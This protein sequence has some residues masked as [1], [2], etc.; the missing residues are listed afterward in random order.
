M[1]ASLVGHH[2]A[3]FNKAAGTTGPVVQLNAVVPAD[4]LIVAWFTFDNFSSTTLPTVTSIGRQ[5][6]ETN[7]WVRVASVPS[8]TATAGSGAVSEIWVIETTVQWS[9]ASYAV[10]L[11]S[12]VTAKVDDVAVFAGVEPTVRGVAGSA[13]SASTTGATATTT[14][15]APVAGDLALGIAYNANSTTVPGTDTDT[16]DG[17]WVDVGTSATSGGSAA[18][19]ITQRAQYK[20]LTGTTAQS[21][22]VSS[23]AVNP[24]GAGCVVLQATPLPSAPA[25]PTVAISANS[26]AI[27]V[28]K[29]ALPAGATYFDLYREPG[30]VLVAANTPPSAVLTNGLLDPTVSYSYY[31]VAG[32]A[33]GTATGSTSSAVVPDPGPPAFTLVPGNTTVDVNINRRDY[34]A[35]YKVYRRLTPPGI[36][37]PWVGAIVLGNVAGATA[38]SGTV[39]ISGATT[40]EVVFVSGLIEDTLTAPVTLPGGWTLVT[41]GEGSQ[42]ASGGSGS[43]S[44]VAWRV[45]QAGDTTFTFSWGVAS[46]Y[47][48]IPFS[49]P[50]V[51]TTT[52][53]DVCAY[54]A[55]TASGTAVSASITPAAANRWAVG[56]FGKR[57]TT[58]AM[59]FTPD[60]ALTER[61][62]VS[63]TASRYMALELADSNGP[64]TQAAHSYT[65][66][67]TGSTAS[68]GGVLLMALIPAGAFTLVHTSATQV[69][70]G[71]YNWQDTGLVNNVDY[72]YAIATEA[73]TPT[74]R[75]SDTGTVK[76][77]APS[78]VIIYTP[79]AVISAGA[80]TGV[81]ATIPV[82]LSNMDDS[83]FAQTAGNTDRLTLDFST[84]T[85]ALISAATTVTLKY[86]TSSVF[87]PDGAIAQTRTSGGLV[88][89]D[90]GAAVGSSGGQETRTW[91]LSATEQAAWVSAINANGGTVYG[92]LLSV[93]VNSDFA[94]MDY[95]WIELDNTASSAINGTAAFTAAGTFAA[96]GLSTNPAAAA[97]TATATFNATPVRTA[98]ATAPLAAVATFTATGTIVVTQAGAVAMTAVG[99]LTP[100]V[101][102]TVIATAALSATATLSVAA[103]RSA[104]AATALTATATFTATGLDTAIATSA[105][106]AVA[107]FTATGVQSGLQAASASLTAVAT[108]IATGVETNLATVAMTAG[109]SMVIVGVISRVAT[110]ALTAIAT[111]VAAGVETLVAAV[112]LTANGTMSI[113]AVRTAIGSVSL[114]AASSMGVAASV[115]RPAT[116]AMTATAAMTVTGVRAAVVTATLVAVGTFT[117]TAVGFGTQAATASLMA[118]GA[119]LALA[120]R[121]VPGTIALAASGLFSA[122]AVPSRDATAALTATNTLS[123]T[124]LDTAVGALTL[125]ASSTTTVGQLVT[126]SAIAPLAGTATFVATGLRDRPG[127]VA[128]TGAAT[129]TVTGIRQPEGAATLN[130]AN[131]FLAGGVIS[132]IATVAMSA[133]ATLVATPFGAVP[134]NVVMTAVAT[135]STT[136]VRA[137]VGSAALT[138]VNTFVAGAVRAQPGT[139]AWQ[140]TGVLTVSSLTVRPGIAPLSAAATFDALGFATRPLSAQFVATALFEALGQV[141]TGN[142]WVR[143]PNTGLYVE[144]EIWVRRYYGLPFEKPQILV[145]PTPGAPFELIA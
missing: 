112:V 80:W 38:L 135:L 60:A 68:H 92:A 126:R 69:A 78:A 122:L 77:T 129:L 44:F 83:K 32:N 79:Q 97:L 128:M 111:F 37:A 123:I 91:V 6:A 64:V 103:V 88:T 51:D 14:G 138:A 49:Y 94:I 1:A 131:S 33:A 8:T 74:V 110:A 127:T 58:A 63:T 66:T 39:D 144:A 10:V 140:A 47:Q 55:A 17:A 28:T 109:G 132:R 113:T 62:D 65:A 73:Q 90:A 120:G 98:P 27:A 137:A 11:G 23:G 116:M 121:S 72:D 99:T 5:A 106:T 86:Q 76:T 134:A 59:A 136:A 105:L 84:L 25:A 13:T 30:G 53:V 9:A 56:M 82:A 20:I 35:K 34:A 26:E 71:V 19:N 114:V 36:S 24:N 50:G 46:K 141:S 61:A 40:G 104:G 31:L 87:N 45:K 48:L 93:S 107:T 29:P 52:P 43:H 4:R 2:V 54:A 117:A 101:V 57:G 96:G 139:A 75:E 3:N 124:G 119:F 143:H 85:A 145:R 70:N 16:T 100:G 95:F 18:T 133:T 115:D 22:S 81:G 41:G 42:G 108:F 89:Q 15:T 118:S 21:F 102:R 67:V 7:N 12:S 130:A 125:T 142:V